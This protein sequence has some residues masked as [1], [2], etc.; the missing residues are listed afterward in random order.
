MKHEIQWD[1]VAVSAPLS[2]A[3]FSDEAGAAKLLATADYAGWQR[4]IQDPADIGRRVPAW[5]PA[6]RP[7][8]S[9][10]DREGKL[11]REFPETSFENP[12]WLD[13]LFIPNGQQLVAYPHHWTSRGLAGQSFLPAD[14]NARTLY[15]LDITSGISQRIDL[16]DTVA[17]VALFANAV[18][19]SCWDGRIYR[20]TDEN[21]KSGRPA[22]GV[23]VGGAAL[24]A[25]APNSSLLFAVTGSGTVSAFDR[26]LKEAWRRDLNNM[27]PEAPKAI[28]KPQVAKQFAPGVWPVLSPGCCQYVVEAPDGLILIDASNGLFFEKSWAA[29]QAIG[30]DPM[31]VRYVLLTHEHGDHAPGAYLWRVAT[32]AKVICGTS[33][34]YSMEHD[35]PLGTGYGFNPPQPADIRIAEDSDMN[36]SGLNVRIVT[37]PGHTPGSI[38]CVFERDGKRF[39]FT[40]D[41]VMR[42]G[43][44]GFFGSVGASAHD[45]LASLRKLQELKPDHL[46]PGHGGMVDAGLIGDGIETGTRT[47]WGLITPETPDPLF[48]ISRKSNTLVTAFVCHAVSADFGDVDGDGR[49]DVVVVSPEGDGSRVRIFLNKGGRFEAMKADWE[50]PLPTVSTPMKIRICNLGAG[51]LPGLFV[52]GFSAVLLSPGDTPG[53]YETRSMPSFNAQQLR[54]A[55]LEGVG[56]PQWFLGTRFNNICRME[57]LKDGL[58]AVRQRDVR[59]M[60]GPY[61]DFQMLDLNGDGRSDLISSYGDLFL[62]G[63]DGRIPDKPTT[64]L[65]QPVS[66]EWRFLGVG[67]FNGDK[68]PDLAFVNHLAA[69]KALIFY[70]TGR[71]DQPFNPKPDTEIDLVDSAAGSAKECIRDEPTVVDWNGDGFSDLVIGM[72]NDKRVRVYL[73]GKSGLD[74]GRVETIPLEFSLHYETHLGVADFNGDGKMDLAVFGQTNT[75]VG[76]TFLNGAVYIL[77]SAGQ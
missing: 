27:V 45:M 3:V 46:L 25:A 72:A 29:I 53:K 41:L 59:N 7:L 71:A 39:A 10:Y 34:A 11:L 56:S 12:G 26:E 38:G 69:N 61:V 35:I 60:A 4:T 62:S 28:A 18:I 47:G 43:N 77:L 75:T 74:A 9:V 31:K 13:L 42:P 8:V 51:K 21:W 44:P 55:D 73:G 24:L 19:A 32:G 22:A 33:A 23:E 52:S 16:P 50:I 70:N 30:L 17:D 58:L 20:L 67:D 40:G 57:P 68:K 63:A 66:G 48:R 49:P 15:R 64:R 37:L 2:T 14:D 54:S 6:T 36:L 5:F 65:L 1:D 76:M